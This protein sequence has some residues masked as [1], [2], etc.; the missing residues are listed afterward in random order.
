[1]ITRA[2]LLE[3]DDSG[4]QQFLRL[5]GLAGEEF[6]QVYRFQPHGFSSVPPVGAEGVVLRMAETE[7]MMAFGFEAKDLRPKNNAGETT[8]I[9]GKKVVIEAAEI[10]IKGKVQITGEKLRHNAKNVGDTHVHGGIVKGGDNTIEPA[11]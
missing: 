11:N 7:R 9:Y 5:K 6:T 1:M 10:E 4:T 8:H 2:K 3:V